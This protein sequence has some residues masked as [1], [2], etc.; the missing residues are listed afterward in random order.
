MPSGARIVM[1]VDVEGTENEIFSKGG[2]FLE[3]FRPDIVCEVLDGVADAPGLEKLLAPYDYR[4]YVVR[5]HDLLLRE[6]IEP[7]VRYRDWLFTGRSAEELRSAGI[8]VTSTE[9]GS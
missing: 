8:P 7:N 5:E 9:P 2:E 6:H 4:H 1:K 3:A